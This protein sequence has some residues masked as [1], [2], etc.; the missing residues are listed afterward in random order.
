MSKDDKKPNSVLLVDDDEFIR[1]IYSTKLAEA[2]IHIAVT[3]DGKKALDIL[4]EEHFDVILV[5]IIMPNVNGIELLKKLG[6]REN[7]EDTKVIVLSNQ[8]QPRD[9]DKAEE[10]DIDG[11]IIKANHVPSE[12]LDEI[13]S[14]YNQ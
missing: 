13:T 11:Y 10:F 8:G 4:K 3:E 1:D 9:I 14:V 7:M 2:G 12:V 5:D 6:E